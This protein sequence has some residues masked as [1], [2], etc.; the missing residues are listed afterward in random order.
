LENVT[1]NALSSAANGRY[2]LSDPRWTTSPKEVLFGKE[3]LIQVQLD[4]PVFRTPTP[5]EPP[6]PTNEP[7]YTVSLGFEAGDVQGCPQS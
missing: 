2:Q 7:Q 5:G 1:L 4:V 6:G 3:L